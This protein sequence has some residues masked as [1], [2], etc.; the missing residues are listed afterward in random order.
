MNILSIVPA[1]VGILIFMSSLTFLLGRK[2][3]ERKIF[4]MNR[5]FNNDI[6]SYFGQ[7][8]QK[9]EV[10]SR[11]EQILDVNSKLNGKSTMEILAPAQLQQN[12]FQKRSENIAA[13][14]LK[15]V[16]IQNADSMSEIK[17]DFSQSRIT[18]ELLNP[19]MI[20]V[21]VNHN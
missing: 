7:D 1:A 13:S 15:S 21:T 4:G 6:P 11:Y 18:Y 2:I 3:T 14:K 10:Y 9:R 16:P 19:R 12:V 5:N 8:N 20:L 17:M